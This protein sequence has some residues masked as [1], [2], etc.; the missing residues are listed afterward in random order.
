MQNNAVHIPMASLLLSNLNCN[1]DKSVDR[2]FDN[3]TVEW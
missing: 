2:E 3:G 1:A